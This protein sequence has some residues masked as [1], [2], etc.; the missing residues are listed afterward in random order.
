MNVGEA[1]RTVVGVAGPDRWTRVC[2]IGRTRD[3]EQV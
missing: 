2:K 1:A 3:T